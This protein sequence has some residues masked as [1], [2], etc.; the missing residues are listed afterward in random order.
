[1]KKRVRI[2]IDIRTDGTRFDPGQ[3]VRALV[4]NLSEVEAGDLGTVIE[5]SQY[6]YVNWDKSRGA[7]YPYTILGV[8]THTVWAVNQDELDWI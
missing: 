1:M 5:R 3:R 7:M 2:K 6:P 4:N 8:D